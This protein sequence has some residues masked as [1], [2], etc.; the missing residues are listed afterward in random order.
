MDPIEGDEPGRMGPDMLSP[1]AKSHNYLNMIVAEQTVKAHNADGWAILL[2]PLRNPAEGIGSKIFL[3]SGWEV[4]HADREV[5][6]AVGEPA[7]DVGPGGEAGDSGGGRG[8]GAFRRGECGRDLFRGAS[9][10][11][12]LAGA[13]DETAGGRLQR[14]GG[15]RFHAAGS[16]PFG[17]IPGKDVM[18][19]GSHAKHN[20]HSPS[21]S[22][23]FA[24][25]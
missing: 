1:R 5:C 22:Q 12:T 23:D 14:R 20:E 24:R 16:G 3:G 4:V 6:A 15:M 21:F 19:I 8:P 10:V 18:L 2:D 25:F 9:W 17:V 13:G 11:R 7:E